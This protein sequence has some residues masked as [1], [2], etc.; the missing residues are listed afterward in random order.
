MNN[1]R[2]KEITKLYE[3]I[4]ATVSD[5]EDMISA[6][7]ELRDEEQEAFDN[8]PESMQASERGEKMEAAV[9]ALNEAI[10]ALEAARDSLDE[11]KT[12]CETAK[13]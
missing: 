2:R 8:L 3:R 12:A 9:S 6:T 4:D 13:E 7:E 10:E 5:L 11:A 1:E